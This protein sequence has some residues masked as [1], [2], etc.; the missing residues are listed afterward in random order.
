MATKTGKAEAFFYQIEAA[1]F[2]ALLSKLDEVGM[3]RFQ[4][5]ELTLMRMCPSCDGFSTN[6]LKAVCMESTLKHFL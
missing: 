4:D 3:R 1:D 6:P 5:L 2:V